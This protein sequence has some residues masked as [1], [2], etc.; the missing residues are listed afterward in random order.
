MSNASPQTR[1]TI[2]TGIPAAAIGIGAILPVSAQQELDAD[3]L[4]I[5][6]RAIAADRR[7]CDMLAKCDEIAARHEGREVSAEDIAER[8]EASDTYRDLRWELLN[9][10]PKTVRG[11]RAIFKFLKADPYLDDEDLEALIESMLVCP[12]LTGG[13][14]V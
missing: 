10:E 11:I 4:D 14:N 8:D 5:S 6:S 1:R 7:Y 9:S 3:I 13:A 12:A 2:L